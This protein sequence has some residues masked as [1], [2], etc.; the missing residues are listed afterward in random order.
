M[1]R[2]TAIPTHTYEDI[3]K[4]RPCPVSTRGECPV[5]PSHIPEIKLPLDAAR[6]SADDDDNDLQAPRAHD[7]SHN[8][9]SSA[10]PCTA[11]TGRTTARAREPACSPPPG[12]PAKA[13]RGSTAAPRRSPYLAHPEEH[14]CHPPTHTQSKRVLADSA[15]KRT[16]RRKAGRS[17]AMPHVAATLRGR[18]SSGVPPSPHQPSATVTPNDLGSGCG[19]FAGS[20]TEADRAVEP[21]SPGPC[22]R[23]GIFELMQRCGS[24]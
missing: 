2:P 7:A 5:W 12:P 4:H 11:G 15:D 1:S 22:R 24:G 16:R 17:P 20:P 10:P 21:R 6:L 13:R 14:P 19:V 8:S 3:R 23:E 9:A 18:S